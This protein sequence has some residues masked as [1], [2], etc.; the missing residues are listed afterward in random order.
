[1]ALLQ[2]SAAARDGA[3]RS[4]SN[5]A[6]AL[7]AGAAVSPGDELTKAVKIARAMRAGP[8]EITRDATVAEMDAHGNMASVLRAAPTSGFVS[9]AMRIGCPSL[10]HCQSISTQL[11][12]DVI[13]CNGPGSLNLLLRLALR[14]GTP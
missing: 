7:P 1:M 6:V 14:W 8:L 2:R 4:Y 10:A 5:A 11:A 9:R 3:S 13:R 12:F